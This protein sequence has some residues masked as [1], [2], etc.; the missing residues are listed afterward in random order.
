MRLKPLT[1]MQNAAHQ[2][3]P[4]CGRAWA[5]C[6]GRTTMSKGRTGASGTVSCTGCSS[7]VSGVCGASSGVVGGTTTTVLSSR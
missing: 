5:S 1:A 4:V 2:F 6:T 3:T 7:G